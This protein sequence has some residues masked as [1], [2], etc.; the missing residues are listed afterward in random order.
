MT[1]YRNCM[2]I[3]ITVDRPDQAQGMRELREILNGSLSSAS[4]MA[5]LASGTNTVIV[6]TV[7]DDEEQGTQTIERVR[8]IVERWH[9]QFN[10]GYRLRVRYI[11]GP[12][13]E[14]LV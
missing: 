6:S 8:R 5:G 2:S 14:I 13:T 10:P 4:I 11:S 12:P 3:F 9:E 7:L 1:T